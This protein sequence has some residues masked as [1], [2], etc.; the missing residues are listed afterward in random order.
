L[1][2]SVTDLKLLLRAVL[3]PI[4]DEAN[5]AT[6][7]G[8]GSVRDS[9]WLIPSLVFWKAYYTDEKAP[10]IAELLPDLARGFRRL[11]AQRN[12]SV[13][14][15][16]AGDAIAVIQSGIQD[17]EQGRIDAAEKSFQEALSKWPRD[18]V[19]K[20][21]VNRYAAHWQAS[22]R[23]RTDM[24]CVNPTK[25]TLDHSLRIEVEA[26]LDQPESPRD[27][28]AYRNLALCLLSS[29]DPTVPKAKASLRLKIA[30]QYG[31]PESWPAEQAAWLAAQLLDQYNPLSDPHAVMEQGVRFLTA[32][33][34]RLP[35][36]DANDAF[37]K[38]VGVCNK[39]G[40]TNWC[41]SLLPAIADARPDPWT[42]LDFAL[43]L[44]GRE[45]KAEVEQ[46]LHWVDR[47]D[48][49]YASE[50]SSAK[51]GRQRFD[52][53]TAYVRA[54]SLYALGVM[55]GDS[56]KLNEAQRFIPSLVDSSAIKE[57]PQLEVNALSLA[58]RVLLD[59]PKP[60]RERA[61]SFQK[62]GLENARADSGFLSRTTFYGLR[63]GDIA[64]VRE[65]VRVA[66]ERASSAAVDS[67]ER[68][69]LLFITAVGGLLTES[70]ASEWAARQFIRTGDVYAPIVSMLL[71]A[72]TTGVAHDS[73]KRLLEERWM[74]VDPSTWD[75]RLRE[76]DRQAWYEMMVGCFEGKVQ[77][78][79]IFDALRDDAALAAS[80]FAGLHVTRRGL[81]TEAYFYDALRLMV[82]GDITG[83][84]ASLRR[85]V[86]LDYKPYI[87]YDIAVHLLSHGLTRD[88][89]AN[90]R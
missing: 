83:S 35:N 41:W 54:S 29:M 62:R 27:R 63:L 59:V 12:A 16:G 49:L 50:I 34:R 10:K 5:K 56:Q 17:L 21:F 68:A 33:V 3:S 15:A 90:S 24:A 75:K 36:Q 88:T 52:F 6:A 73:A 20:L 74:R 44:S 70:D 40:P 22:R 9:D 81:L 58:I 67:Q 89:A 78:G 32:A 18:E 84:T 19:E 14:A 37:N 11:Q 43:T 38:L 8:E 82:A 76:G 85:V 64:T 87:E 25:G 1:G 7:L 2:I 66:Y 71:S 46:A 28:T 53:W 4:S 48:S 31:D 77:A 65:N 86:D 47:A 13:A 60:D 69:S 80:Q 45:S 57:D 30:G 72:R 39:P 51:E 23:T 55:D 26:M 42:A 79:N 61:A